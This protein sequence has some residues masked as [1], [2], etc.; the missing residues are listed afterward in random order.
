[1]RS[2]LEKIIFNFK[3]GG[4]MKYLMSL[5]LLMVT[6]SSYAETTCQDFKNEE[7]VIEVIQEKKIL[8][9]ENWKDIDVI[10]NFDKE[11]CK[12][13]ILQELI[14]VNGEYFWR[15]QTNEDSCDGGNTY[16]S[17][18]TSDLKKPIVHIY[19]SEVV[20]E[21]D[22]LAEEK[23]ENHKC[24][25]SAEV[26]AQKKMKDFG[27]EFEKLSSELKLREPYIYS[28]IRVSG[29][30][31]NKGGKQATVRVLADVKTCHFESASI[32]SLEL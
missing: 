22:W 17:I 32:E 29:V 27:L 31:T 13:S 15:F 10:S 8:N 18:Y 9:K 23:A 25:E 7:A 30:I 20:C 26:Y 19:D 5:L 2:K 28:F 12:D 6:A 3:I 21:N 1:M 24:D 16:G 14:K 11:Q 4:L